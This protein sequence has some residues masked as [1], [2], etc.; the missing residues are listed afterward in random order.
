MEDFKCVTGAII[1][2]IENLRVIQKELD[3]SLIKAIGVLEEIKTEE[4]WK[5]E[6]E[7]VG[8][9]FLDLVV[10][11]HSQIAGDKEDGPVTQAYKGLEEYV[12]NDGFF[13]SEWSQYQTI[14][15]M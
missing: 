5:G 15:E 12:S 13:Y 2:I 4:A 7:L 6:A 3:N 10:Q 1:P 9:A 11:Y 14:K 8:K